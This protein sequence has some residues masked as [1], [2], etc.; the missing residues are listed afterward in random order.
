MIRR[1]KEPPSL[2]SRG[3]WFPTALVLA[4]SIAACQTSRNKQDSLFGKSANQIHTGAIAQ[5]GNMLAA[6]THLARKWQKK[7]GDATLGLQYANQL[8]RINSHNKAL[9]ILRQTAMANPQN[10]MVLLAYGNQLA[11]LKHYRQANNVLQKAHSTGKPHWRIYAAQ[12]AV[13]DQMRRHK[14]AQ[15]AHG[16]ALKLAPGRP[17]IINNIAMSYVMA[18]KLKKAE[19]TLRPIYMRTNANPKIRQ[20]MALIVGLQGRF[21]EADKIAAAD[22]PPHTVKAN[23]AYLRQMLSQ[24]N[25]WKKV[26][27]LNKG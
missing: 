6:T 24:P 9:S 7:R 23:I 4:T 1:L 11:R 26:K 25:S 15:I 19:A 8:R 5:P 17:S 14:N 27:K 20:N 12:G 22:L 2:F 16:Y 21:K 10:Q 3:A 18:G 13:L